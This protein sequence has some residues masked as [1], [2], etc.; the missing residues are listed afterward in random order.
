[1]LLLRAPGNRPPGQA[2]VLAF[3]SDGVWFRGVGVLLTAIF[4]GLGLILVITFLRG[5]FR[6]DPQGGN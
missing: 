4:G 1:M 2:I 6:K 3:E 5:Y